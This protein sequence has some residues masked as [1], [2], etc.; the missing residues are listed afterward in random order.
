[1]QTYVVRAGDSPALIAALHAGCPKC[2]VDLVRANPHKPS[3][4]MPNGF[5]TFRDLRAGEVLNL[6]DKWFN[7]QLEGLPPTYFAAL[8][9]AD[10][11]TR[12]SIGA[13]GDY[14]ELDAAT[15][16]VGALAAMNDLDFNAAV[17]DAGA[18][19]DASVMEAYGSSN[20]AAAKLARDVQDGT[21]W[22]WQRNG[23]LTTAIQAGDPATIS[24]VRLD[25]QNALST[26]LGN[27][28][29]A[30][31]AYFGPSA[32]TVSVPVVTRPTYPAGVVGAAQAAA[33]AIAADASYCSSVARA[34]SAVNAAVHAFK[35]AWN[36]AYPESAVPIGTGT[37]EAATAGA[38]AQVLGSSPPACG[39]APPAPL[40]PPARTTVA[41]IA[42][43]PAR[44]LSTGAVVGIGLL[45]AGT[46]G[47][48][49]YVATR[50]R[51][52]RVRRYR[53]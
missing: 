50:K 29:L 45:A 10:G 23:D 1:M 8:P 42:A 31:G 43:A 35:A 28:R 13:L 20:A 4:T 51:G 49:A 5:S 39:A 2:A 25:I 24:S 44:G 21:H 33:A 17:G 6:P 26:A 40:P 41:P 3:V 22:A 7:G 14:P 34:G 30:L 12:G 52:A 27:A 48:I 11:V 47:G 32:P 19:I 37:Y 9:Y 18:A 36:A 16:K 46:V 38:L 15:S 53:G